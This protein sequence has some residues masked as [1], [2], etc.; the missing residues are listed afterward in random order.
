M[1]IISAENLRSVN[2]NIVRPDVSSS[3][4]YLMYPINMK[5]DRT[6]N[7]RDVEG[8]DRIHFTLKQYAKKQDSAAVNPAPGSSEAPFPTTKERIKESDQYTRATIKMGG[9]NVSE[10]FLPIQDKI[11]DTNAVTWADGTLNDLQRRVANLSYNMMAK[12]NPQVDESINAMT[13]I[14]NDGNV[15]NLGRLYLVEQIIGV[16]G[17]LSRA[18][19][20]V[21]NPNLELLFSTPTLRPFTFNFKL[22]PRD[23]IEGSEV[24]KI[25]RFFK[26]GMAPRVQATN[27]FLNAPYVFDIKY[28]MGNKKEHDGIGK[29]K[30]C[31]LQNC[32]VDYTPNNS[33]M[34]YQEGTMVSY[35]INM[36]FQ[37][38]VPIYDVDYET[39]ETIN[40]SIGY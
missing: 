5:N 33:Y 34:T 8:Q 9:S 18:T 7:G 39:D 6:V 13:N 38:I 26:Q 4:S 19:G 22:S 27:L 1:P 25:I 10:V 23:E 21:L 20:K 3:R 12:D 16:Q 40:H 37:E 31:A 28:M 32:T 35:N 15:G 29:I 11:Q 24:K 30:H 2:K 36:T 17:L 14:L